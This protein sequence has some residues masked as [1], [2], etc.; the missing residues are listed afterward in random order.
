[1]IDTFTTIRKSTMKLF[2]LS[3]AT[4]MIRFYLMMGIVVL[5]GF[6][7]FWLISVLSLPVFFSALMGIQFNKKITIKKTQ[8]SGRTDSH[9]HLK[10]SAA[11][12]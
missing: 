10:Q 3:V 8:R 1:M 5:A 7:G 6:S 12:A 2:R 4:L 9:L 11:H